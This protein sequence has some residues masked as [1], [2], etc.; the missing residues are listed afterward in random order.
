M[1]LEVEAKMEME[2]ALYDEFEMVE[3]E[4]VHIKNL[5]T[6]K[7]KYLRILN[8]FKNDGIAFNTEIEKCNRSL[9]V[10]RLKLKSLEKR[11][12]SIDEKMN[13]LGCYIVL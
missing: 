5:I 11:Y 3:S 2:L 4:I 1:S 7:S 12:Y 10:L 6:E 8:D 13:E 9:K